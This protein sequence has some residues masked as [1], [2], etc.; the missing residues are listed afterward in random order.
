MFEN[1]MQ[2]GDKSLN[3]I[4]NYGRNQSTHGKPPNH[5]SLATFSLAPSI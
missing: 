3:S 4:L 5:M 1:D 2:N